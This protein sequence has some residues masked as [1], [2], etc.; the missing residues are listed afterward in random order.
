MSG[1][2][3][4]AIVTFDFEDRKKILF[5]T[6]YISNLYSILRLKTFLE[7]PIRLCVYAYF[8]SKFLL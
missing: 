8:L 5:V 4:K 1:D 6:F 3:N 2:G 7:I